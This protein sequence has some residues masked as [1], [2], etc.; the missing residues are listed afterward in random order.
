LTELNE[1]CGRNQ[2]YPFTNIPNVGNDRLQSSIDHRTCEGAKASPNFLLHLCWSQVPF[3]L[4][5]GKRDIGLE[6]KSED[7][8]LV[9][10]KAVEQLS[11]LGLFGPARFTNET[12]LEQHFLRIC[13]HKNEGL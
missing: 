2:G 13:L 5:V 1:H 8:C 6:D 12:R 4:I 10:S 3:S 11:A 7:S 9:F